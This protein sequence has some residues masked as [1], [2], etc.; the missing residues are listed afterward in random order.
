MKLIALICGLIGI[1]LSV[2]GIYRLH[3][4]AGELSGAGWLLFGAYRLT[5][6][7]LL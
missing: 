3:P 7:R 5:R 4:I 6:A 1:G 2:H